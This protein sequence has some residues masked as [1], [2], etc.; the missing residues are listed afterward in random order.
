MDKNYLK[1]FIIAFFISWIL[2]AFVFL[3]QYNIY[4][5]ASN[6]KTSEFSCGIKF[7]RG[8]P[9]KFT[10]VKTCEQDKLLPYLFAP[11]LL[12]LVIVLVLKL[13]YKIDL[14]KESKKLFQKK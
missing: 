8:D 7:G 6:I 4:S 9:Y 1:F 3:Y 2:G 5:N 10:D 12:L 14:F 11:A 13:V